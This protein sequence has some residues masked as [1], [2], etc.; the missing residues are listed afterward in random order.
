MDLLRPVDGSKSTLLKCK[1]C[2]KSLGASG[3]GP[4]CYNKMAKK[5]LYTR[6]WVVE[7]HDTPNRGVGAFVAPAAEIEKK[8][9]VAVY[10]GHLVRPNPANQ[11]S[12]IFDLDGGGGTEFASTASRPAAG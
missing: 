4:E 3:C 1:S 12:Y 8:A 6:R 7:R 9:C 10:L 5:F 2:K 11:S